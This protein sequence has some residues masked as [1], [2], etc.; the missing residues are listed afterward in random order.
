VVVAVAAFNP[1]PTEDWTTDT[2]NI[3]NPSPLID[4]D[5]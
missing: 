4:V 1:N 5:V 3:R 2:K